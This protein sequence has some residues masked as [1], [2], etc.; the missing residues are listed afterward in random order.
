VEELSH[1]QATQ[2]APSE[3]ELWPPVDSACSGLSGLR[4]QG[5]EP[6]VGASAWSQRTEGRL[7]GISLLPCV[8][9]SPWWGER[10]LGASIA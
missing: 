5:S 4:A 3:L 7:S 2:T 9:W 10:V 6:V 1:V 8:P